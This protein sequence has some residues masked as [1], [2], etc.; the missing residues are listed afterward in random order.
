MDS[1]KDK[2]YEYMHENIGLICCT[3]YQMTS[4]TETWLKDSS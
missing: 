2:I 4:R 1:E 3:I